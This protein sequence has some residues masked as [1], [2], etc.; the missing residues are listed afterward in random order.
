MGS[1]FR[2]QYTTIHPKTGKRVTRKSKKYYI[3]YTVNG[4]RRREPAFTDKTASQVLL[5]KRI[6]ESEREAVGITDHLTIHLSRPI[7]EHAAEFRDHLIHRGGGET[8]ATTQY[9]RIAWIC[10]NAMIEKVG[11][12]T[13]SRVDGAI[14]KLLAPAKGAKE[15]GEQGRTMQ[16]PRSLATRNHY[17][18][19]MKAFT[20]WLVDEHRA[21]SDMLTSL[22]KRPTQG[23]ETFSRRPLTPDEFFRLIEHAR[24]A[25]PFAGIDGA[26]RAA[27]YIVAAYT[28]YRRSELATLEPESFE[29]GNE[30]SVSLWAGAS[31]RKK[32]ERI[33]LKTSV[34]EGLREWVESKPR[35]AKLWSVGEVR[36]ADMIRADLAAIDVSTHRPQAAGEP[37]VI[38]D[39][40]SLR[41]TFVTSLARAGVVPKLAQQL[42]RH[43]TINLTMNVYSHLTTD[44]RTAAVESLPDLT[45]SLTPNLTPENDASGRKQK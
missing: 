6:L 28:G 10:E 27:L 22:R 16:K 21:P 25:E 7:L 41:Q 4:V 42:A 20:A 34:A 45:Q 30:P 36:T 32:K 33:P 9:N 23:F 29:F 31:K 5:A 15:A 35:G 8:H 18:G 1:V 24:T 11:D 38:V 37:P 14:A 3:Q 26:D 19:A 39:F 40:H 44:E 12:I 13:A 17:A 43:S 2:Q